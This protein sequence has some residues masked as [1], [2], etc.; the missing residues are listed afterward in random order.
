M[1]LSAESS[2]RTHDLFSVRAIVRASLFGCL[3]CWLMG[4][5]GGGPRRAAVDGQVSI[6]QVALENGTISFSPTDGNSGPTAGGSI[7]NGS[8]SIDD[9]KGP[10]VGWNL[11]T[12]SGARK[13][14]KRIPEPLHGALVD[15]VVS[16]VPEQYNNRSTLKRELKPGRNV[17]DFEL[18]SK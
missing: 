7:R 3:S 16:V 5:G 4:C 15:E 9:E 18:S 11:I 12:I 14:G 8:Y 17:L 10:A 2:V 6:D 1:T 13:T